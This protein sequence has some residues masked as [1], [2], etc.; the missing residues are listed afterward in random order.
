MPAYKLTYF[1][2]RARGEPIR[3]IFAQ[4]GVPLEDNRVTFEQWPALKP[5][6]PF[7]T[8]PVLEEDGKV[9]SG[10]L[11]IARYLAEKFG[12]AGSN[13]WENGEVASV[14]DFAL[15][16][17]QRMFKGHF[18]KDEARKAEI[19]KE[20]KEKEFPKF[21][22]ILNERISS[23]GFSCLNRLT[24]ADFYIYIISDYILKVD[25]NVLQ[26]YPKLLQLRKMVAELPNIAKWLKERPDTF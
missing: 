8:L 14:V 20:S 22:R 17:Q 15:D 7:E 21:F 12:L 25:E 13:E 24:Y 19:V 3:F 16:L 4:A 10:N 23:D 18:E 6:L 11:P 2:V 1:N 9:L 5:T 26:D